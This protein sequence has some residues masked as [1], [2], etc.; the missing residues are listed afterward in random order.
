MI[1]RKIVD[2]TTGLNS[3]CP[4]ASVVAVTSEAAVVETAFDEVTVFAV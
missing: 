3:K 1:S 2:I 4:L